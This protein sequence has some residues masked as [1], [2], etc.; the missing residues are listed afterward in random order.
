MMDL[1]DW[2]L[3][4]AVAAVLVLYIR[5]MRKNRRLRQLADESTR[6]RLDAEAAW[7][8]NRQLKQ[9]LTSNIAHELKTPVSSIRGYLETLL[10]PHPV[11]DERRHY[12]LERCY[13]QTLRLTDLIRDVS[14]INKLEES[15][16]LFP[17]A[18]VD[19]VAVVGEAIDEL[20]D[21]AQSAS[22]TIDNRLS[23]AMPILGNHELLY[24]IF[25]NLIENSIT[26][27][28]EGCQIVISTYHPTRL[29]PPDSY[30]YI[31]YYDD[32]VGVPDEYLARLFDRFVR[33]DSGRSRR[34]GGT[35]LGLSIVKHA[36]LFH[37]GEIYAKNR[38]QGGLEYFLSLKKN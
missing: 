26:H 15:A 37:N 10:G 19:V 30:Y 29:N 1:S 35:G 32:G 14:I 22:I 25:R 20:A 7:Q 3:L 2:V 8:R 12:Y 24:C 16:D 21:R 17:R 28:G 33:I 31:H 38:P 27:A 36:V 5:L 13:S 11:D 23:D 9:E 6:L 4:A 34:N 18:E